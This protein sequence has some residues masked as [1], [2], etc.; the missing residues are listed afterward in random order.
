MNSGNHQPVNNAS[1][2][3][4]R[5][6]MIIESLSETSI[7][8][9]GDYASVFAVADHVVKLQRAEGPVGWQAGL[10]RLH[11][12]EL[13]ANERASA[14]ARLAG[15]VAR[16]FGQV[17]IGRVTDASGHDVSDRYLLSLGIVLERLQGEAIKLSEAPILPAHIW[18]LLDLFSD[19]GIYAN[20]ASVFGLAS[21]DD[22]KF[23][24][25]TTKLGN[26]LA[27]TLTAQN[28]AP[29]DELEQFWNGE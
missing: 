4:N 3:R 29:R 23:I 22:C 5:H 27:A 24:D 16:S 17:S 26:R 12:E 18:K 8:G 25:I 10:V 21:E 2:L 11:A 14:D 7:I 19:C 28:A 1:T 13:S 6:R 20:D 15:H 9:K